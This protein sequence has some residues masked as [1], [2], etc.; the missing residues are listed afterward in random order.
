MTRTDTINKILSYTV[1]IKDLEDQRKELRRKA[2]FL[3]RDITEEKRKLD[4]FIEE[5]KNAEKNRK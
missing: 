2:N 1:K 4:Y 3:T 5:L